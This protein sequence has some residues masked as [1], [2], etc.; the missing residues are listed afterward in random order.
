MCVQVADTFLSGLEGAAQSCINSLPSLNGAPEATAITDQLNQCCP[1]IKKVRA[2]RRSFS[3]EVV[4]T[5]YGKC[6]FCYIIPRILCFLVRTQVF[7]ESCQ[8]LPD[9]SEVIPN[10]I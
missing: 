5:D 8:C 9:I 7:P 2:A 10:K 1:V 6:L 3:H 4:G